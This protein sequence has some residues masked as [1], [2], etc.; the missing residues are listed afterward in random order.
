MLGWD[1]GAWW[2]LRDPC[3][4]CHHLPCPMREW[5]RAH[6]LSPCCP[7]PYPEFVGGV[8]QGGRFVLRGRMQTGAKKEASWLL[9]LGEGDLAKQP[10]ALGLGSE[11]SC[12]CGFGSS[13][14]HLPEATPTL[15]PAR[16]SSPHT[17]DLSPSSFRGLLPHSHLRAC[18]RRGQMGRPPHVFPKPGPGQAPSN[19]S[20]AEARWGDSACQ[21]CSGVIRL[22]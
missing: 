16:P 15:L 5:A 12:V 8:S 1:A 22:S 4:R 11:A 7:P 17:P 2:V 20:R 19:R 6:P 14:S 3:P 21:A 9:A 18:L 13:C 10:R